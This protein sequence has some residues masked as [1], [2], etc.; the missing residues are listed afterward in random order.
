MSIRASLG[1]D[2]DAFVVLVQGGNYEWGDRKSFLVAMQAFQ[3][4]SRKL[5]A[6][7]RVHLYIHAIPSSLL[8]AESPS[9]VPAH[10]PEKGLP[11]A[12]LLQALEIPDE[13]WTLNVLFFPPYVRSLKIMAD[14]CLHPSKTEGFGLN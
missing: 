6:R 14:V 13:L 9:E 1:I 4:M 12:A 7:S 2:P 11:L 8:N 10:M 3:D 5:D